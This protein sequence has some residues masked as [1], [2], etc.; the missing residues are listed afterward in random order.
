MFGPSYDTTATTTLIEND[1]IFSN[2]D[3]RLTLLL[4]MHAF[5]TRS[6]YLKTYYVLLLSNS[7]AVIGFSMAR[8]VTYFQWRLSWGNETKR[9]CALA[10]KNSTPIKQLSRE[11]DGY[12]TKR[13][14][15]I[16][17]I[18]TSFSFFSSTLVSSRHRYIFLSSEKTDKLSNSTTKLSKTRRIVPD[19]LR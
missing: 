7:D 6:L 4:H 1:V 14:N 12:T 2:F 3:E 10:V 18:F 8:Y 13:A 5:Q 17:P 9:F 19:A 15:S 11:P 16:K